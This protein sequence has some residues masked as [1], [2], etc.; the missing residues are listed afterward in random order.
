MSLALYYVLL[1]Q[2]RTVTSETLIPVTPV[3]PSEDVRHDSLQ[4]FQEKLPCSEKPS[5]DSR[6]ESNPS[7]PI[8]LIPTVFII[9]KSGW[10][11]IGSTLARICAGTSVVQILAGARELTLL[12]NIQS[13]S[14]D[15]P[16]SNSMKIT[17]SSLAVKWPGLWVSSLTS[18]QYQLYNPL[19][20]YTH[21]SSLPPWHILGQFYFTF[22]S[23]L[24]TSPTKGG[25]GLV[26][27][28]IYILFTTWTM[29]ITFFD[30]IMLT[31]WGAPITKLIIKLSTSCY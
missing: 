18:I 9:F 16:A 4:E 13:S 7:N 8:L 30:P 5:R 22:T 11:N 20:L 25:S 6:H 10:S 14:S 28:F 15:Q 24:C 17:D 29:Y 26:G 19:E 12:Q 23:Y 3:P 27:S 31:L 21:L 1:L 2:W